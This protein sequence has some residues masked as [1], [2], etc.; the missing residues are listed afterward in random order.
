MSFTVD[1]RGKFKTLP[2]LLAF[3]F[4]FVVFA[5]W[6]NR[7]EWFPELA[8]KYLGPKP[9]ASPA[10]PAAPS[11]YASTQAPTFE[12]AP[13][14]SKAPA[15]APAPQASTPPSFEPAP[16]APAAPAPKKSILEDPSQW[17]QTVTLTRAI[18]VPAMINGKQVGM[19]GVP[20]GSVVELVEIRNGKA[21]VRHRSGAQVSVA[22]ED[23]DILSHEGEGAV[24][25][26]S[27]HSAAPAAKSSAPAPASRPAAMSPYARRIANMLVSYDGGAMKPFPSQK[28]AGVRYFAIYRSAHWCPPCRRFTPELVKFYEKTKRE[29]P[30]FELVFV[31]RDK[32]AEA[33]EEYMKVMSMPWP[34]L[35]YRL[36]DSSAGKVLT[37]YPG[38][39]I[40][41]LMLVDSDG[42]LL[43]SSY[44]G[45]DYV[46][47][48]KV[49]KD[50]QDVLSGKSVATR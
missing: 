34:A 8:E 16:Q 39:G 18:S 49:M 23:T 12:P 10:E 17:P 14:T 24:A 19:M 50:I 35:E 46:G 44:V 47:P 32:S 4:F 45:E 31:S 37:N 9:E 33:M 11:S 22:V 29:H 41:N 7:Y 40:P 36:V 26:P 27:T 30:E 15:F 25:A 48:H 5:C 6:M 20:A 21:V 28:L 3:I 42:K 2:L 13:A 1:E 38:T 43:S